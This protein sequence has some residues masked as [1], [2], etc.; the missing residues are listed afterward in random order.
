MLR[1]RYRF[2]ERCSVLLLRA[3][4]DQ[5]S[6]VLFQSA[7]S[8][9]NNCALLGDDPRSIPHSVKLL[10]RDREKMHGTFFFDAI[11]DDYG[12]K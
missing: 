3:S 8:I 1:R 4:L 11:F 7:V 12:P 9:L 10:A 5:Q 2:S 6:R